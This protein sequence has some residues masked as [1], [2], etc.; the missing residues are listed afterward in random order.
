MSNHE[1]VQ[2]TETKLSYAKL[3]MSIT[4]QG[5]VRVHSCPWSDVL[6]KLL[7]Q[8]KL[9]SSELGLTERCNFYVVAGPRSKAWFQGNLCRIDLQHHWSMLQ[10]CADLIMPDLEQAAHDF[11]PIAFKLISGKERHCCC[12]IHLHNINPK[13]VFN[14]L[15]CNGTSCQQCNKTHLSPFAV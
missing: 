14:L 11:Q 4:P 2:M 7:W 6:D 15:E 9:K 8:V 1:P 13:L 5:Q 12:S 10:H 3:V